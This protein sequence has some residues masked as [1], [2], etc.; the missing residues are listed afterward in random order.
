MAFRSNGPVT[1]SFPPFRGVTR[2][3]VLLALVCFLAE[4]AFG[5]VSVSKTALLLDL[6]LLHPGQALHLYFWQFVTYPFVGMGLL[7]LLLALLSVWIFGAMLEDERG[8][9]WFTEFFLAATIAGGLLAT[10][11]A[12][13]S[14][15]HVPGLNPEGLI[16]ASGMWP[17]SLALLVAFAQLHAEE[18]IRFNFVFKLKAKYL[19]ALYVAFY[20][21]LTLLGGDR[22]SGLVALMNAAMGYCFVRFVPRRGLRAGMTERWFGLRNDWYRAKRRRAARKF[23]VYM[24]KQ[25]KEVSLDADGRYIDPNGIHRDPNDRNW[26]N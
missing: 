24:R 8:P 10:L 2:R 5:M 11:L 6:L 17:F 16:R 23:A 14:G 12:Y 19:A 26:M 21:V 18:V 13:A 1:L 4:V 9:R 7:S 3:I 20:L 25:G 15:G 22:F